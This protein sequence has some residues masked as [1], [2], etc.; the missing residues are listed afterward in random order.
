[1]EI[2]GR[3]KMYRL[4]SKQILA[5]ALISALFAGL[6]VAIYDRYGKEPVSNAKSEPTAA[7]TVTISNPSVVSEEQNNIEI[8]RAVS[9]SVVNITSTTYVQDFFDVYPREGTGSGSIIDADGHILTNYHVIENA[10]KLD[11]ALADNSHYPARIVGV[12][13]DN[14][15][16]VI[17]INVPRSKLNAVKLGN[18]GSLQVGQKVLAIGNPFGLNQTLT[19][20]VISGL[21]RPLRAPNGRLIENVI[22][23]DASIN[24]GNSGGPLLNSRGEVIGI[25]S[26]IFTPSGGSVGVGFAVPVDTA[27]KLI[28]DLIAYGRA[29]RPWLGIRSYEV[30]ARLADALE[31]PVAEGLLV[32]EVIR[33]GSADQAGI[34][35]GNIPTNVRG[36]YVGGDVITKIDGQPI[37]N[38]DD[39]THVLNNK[40][41]GDVVSVEVIRNGRRM[42]LSM[43]LQ[44]KPARYN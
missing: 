16:A 39:L 23:T 2:S 14:D 41:P 19:T 36:L 31:L 34:R 11:V 25:N 18:S 43:K 5:L 4:T 15:L 33:G 30:N 21:G 44:E 12:D 9:P 1:M 13:P 8:Y 27:K 10:Q 35:G 17:K 24:P 40:K 6:L 20:G 29:R 28:P 22:Q 3:E 38:Q 26:A 37:R 32:T 42:T 7:P